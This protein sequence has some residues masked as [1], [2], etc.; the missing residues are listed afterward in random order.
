[1]AHIFEVQ[2]PD[3]SILE[4][5]AP[6]D[7]P[8]AAIKQRAQS[9]WNQSRTMPP[10]GI[11]RPAL[12]EGL[13]PPSN[14]AF[15]P[16]AMRGD[17]ALL[18]RLVG[19][20]KW[21]G[22]TAMQGVQWG[23]NVLGMPVSPTPMDAKGR[24]YLAPTNPEQAAGMEG[25]G[26]AAAVAPIGKGAQ[27]AKSLLPSTV[28]AGKKFEQIMAAAGDLPIDTAQAEEVA[29]RALELSQRGSSLPKVF[30]N[31]IKNRAAKP[32]KMGGGTKFQMP[33][34]PMTYSVG[35][36][37]ASNAGALS[38]TERTAMNAKMQAQ[39]A[40]LADA[41]KQANR[42]PADQVGMGRLYDEA[43]KEYAQAKRLADAL[44]ATK[45]FAKKAAPIA[46]AGFL[47]TEL[48][49]RGLD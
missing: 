20:G 7:T 26:Y 8:I 31:F 30:G 17:E 46:G 2:M 5:D 43:M 18:Q 47:G 48:I 6:K 37:F 14:P 29:A 38:T 44:A 34:D 12:P 36:D 1:M 41:L 16:A 33:P 15:D 28:R 11:P 49:R 21:A 3:G 22:D 13:Q 27:L 39:V 42:G 45:K 35:R 19:A 40:K 32:V 4:I 23:Q 24:E 9:H 25:A 10:P